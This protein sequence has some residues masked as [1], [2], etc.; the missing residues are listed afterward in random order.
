MGPNLPQIPE[1]GVELVGD[2]APVLQVKVP[3]GEAVGR[4]DDVGVDGA[5]VSVV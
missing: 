5:D 4:V 1:F 2:D 3:D